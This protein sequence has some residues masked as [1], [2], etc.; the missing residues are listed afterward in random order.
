MKT[1]KAADN[2]LPPFSRRLDVTIC[3]AL[4]FMVWFCHALSRNWTSTDSR[5]TIPTA[6][7][8]L[9]R[10]SARLDHFAPLIEQD[11]FYA[12]DCV[13]DSTVIRPLHSL[14]QCA[15]G[16]LYNF[17]PIGV[18]VLAVPEVYVIR[19]LAAVANATPWISGM[20]K[21]PYRRRFL[22]GDLVYTHPLVEVLIASFW[23][24][25]ATVMT[26][27]L[28]RRLLNPVRSVA[29]AL[30]FAFCTPAWS[31]ASRALWQHGASVL[32]IS[33]ALWTL[34]S[35]ADQPR[36]LALAGFSLAFAIVVRPTNVIVFGAVLAYLL[37][38]R[39]P[40]LPLFL[41]AAAPV[42]VAF[43]AWSYS[44]YGFPVAPYYWPHRPGSNSL[45]LSGNFPV[46]LAGN[47]ISPGR[48][49]FVFV[50]VFLLAPIGMFQTSL[51]AAYVRLRP[52]LIAAL[53]GHWILISSF[54]DWWA[55]FSFGPRYFS[56]VTPLFVFFLLPLLVA[57][58]KALA[59]DRRTKCR[60][61]LLGV[62]AVMSFAIQYRG[63]NRQAA[64]D[65]NR[66][67]VSIDQNPQRVWDWSD[68]AFFR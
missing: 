15:G 43:A 1:G 25:L 17:Y 6:L 33:V 30:L 52:F 66:T 23:I 63:A 64:F 68:L 65:W 24:A 4:F 14:A 2:R 35:A 56:D 67:P 59:A 55:G 9:D 27:L 53:I 47:L 57:R 42:F 39:S 13:K 37:L 3:A 26:Y 50:P 61:A 7:S 60:L 8:I 48:G 41:A 45:E 11:K 54:R 62:L 22:E 18:A 32:L 28:A 34:L 16:H 51:D 20:V 49:L 36:W 31:T 46:A 58:G 12:I 29:L 38:T 40:G 21:N 19:K 5:W 10:H 44:V